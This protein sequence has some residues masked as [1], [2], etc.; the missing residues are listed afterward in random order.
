VPYVDEITKAQ[1]GPKESGAQARQTALAEVTPGLINPRM[2]PPGPGTT[3]PI[4]LPSGSV[5]PPASLQPANSGSIVQARKDQE[6]NATQEGDWLKGIGAATFAENRLM[7]IAD[8][9]K[10]FQSG[11]FQGNLADIRAKLS[12]VGIHVPDSFAG[13]P[14]KA[15]QILKDNFAASVEMMKSTGLSR[16][17]QQELAGA[18]TA[19]ANPGLQP[20]AN[21]SILAQAI[22][23]I[24][25]ERGMQEAYAQ[26][27]QYGWSNPS[28]FQLYYQQQNPLAPVVEKTKQDLGPLKGMPQ[29]ASPGTVLPPG[30]ARIPRYNP[31]TGKLE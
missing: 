4:T 20:A 7:A 16:W 15:Q 29:P 11:A 31:D 2:L 22:G 25:W 24:R 28:A 13:D 26:A 14:A 18:Q 17:T 8:A 21:H 30:G 19:M 5:L 1:A 10:T 3:Q 9:L 27:K 23:A 12:A 6:I